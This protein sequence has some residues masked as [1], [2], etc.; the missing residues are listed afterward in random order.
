LESSELASGQEAEIVWNAVK[1]LPQDLAMA[2]IL[3]YREDR[4]IKEIADIMKKR[5]NTIKV[6]LFRGREK[7]KELLGD[8]IGGF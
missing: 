2:I 3:Y 8:K 1:K 4:N 5:Q 6:H 7:L